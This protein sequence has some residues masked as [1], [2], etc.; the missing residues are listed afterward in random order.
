MRGTTASPMPKAMVLV[1]SSMSRVIPTLSP[2]AKELPRY[3]AFYLD[4]PRSW[5]W[6]VYDRM[7]KKTVFSNMPKREAKRTARHM[8]K[9]WNEDLR[10]FRADLDSGVPVS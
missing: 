3:Y 6:C 2:M 10:Q 5:T 7:R 8:N 1:T 9:N 4:Y